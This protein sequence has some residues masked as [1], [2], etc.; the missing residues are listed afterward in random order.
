[1][2]DREPGK[3]IQPIKTETQAVENQAEVSNPAEQPI[4]PET[5]LDRKIEYLEEKIEDLIIIPNDITDL[6]SKAIEVMQKWQEDMRSYDK[7]VEN[8]VIPKPAIGSSATMKVR[9]I[10]R[11]VSK[12]AG[13]LVERVGDIFNRKEVLELK[14]LTPII[15]IISRNEYLT[16]PKY[17]EKYMTSSD[18]KTKDSLATFTQQEIMWERK[19]DHLMIVDGLS[20]K[21][22]H[23]LFR[24]MNGN[25]WAFLSGDRGQN[26]GDIVHDLQPEEML[27]DAKDF[28][29]ESKYWKKLFSVGPFCF[30]R[31]HAL[32]EEVGSENGTKSIILT[33]HVD[34]KNWVVGIKDFID[35][36]TG[37]IPENEHGVVKYHALP[38]DGKSHIG[39]GLPEMGVLLTINMLIKAVENGII[40]NVEYDPKKLKELKTTSSIVEDDKLTWE[41]VKMNEKQN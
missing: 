31:Y 14:E 15:S 41:M 37:K 38:T 25:P 35:K 19:M 23:C 39:T 10:G 32:A 33:A 7:Q 27:V 36:A 21:Q 5:G 9:S 26:G 24:Q 13:K 40:K 8:G 18:N 29:E 11:N 3:E 22:L 12:I 4:P 16:N 30:A 6:N 17:L 20:L 28:P 1:M 34:P 2:A